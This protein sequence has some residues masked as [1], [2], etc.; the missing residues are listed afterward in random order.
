MV[1]AQVAELGGSL[2]LVINQLALTSQLVADSHSQGQAVQGRVL[3][4][5]TGMA[6]VLAQVGGG[7]GVRCMSKRHRR[8]HPFPR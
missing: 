2:K 6:Q 8:H 3:G 1:T 4:M 7:W 5:E